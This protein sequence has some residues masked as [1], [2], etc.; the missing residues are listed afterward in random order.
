[1]SVRLTTSAPRRAGVCIIA[2]TSV[3]DATSK[4]DTAIF[5]VITGGPSVGKTTIISL[6]RE[7]GYPVV[8]EQATQ[9]IKEGKI[10][11]WVD[12]DL[13]QQ[14]VLRRQI[15]V[16][17]PYINSETPVFLDRG[18]FD[19]EAYY[20]CDGLPTPPVFQTMPQ[21]RYA[22]ALLIEELPF[23]DN[24]GVRFEDIEFTRKI[25]PVIEKCYT[26]RGIHVERVPALPPK[27]RVDYAVRVVSACLELHRAAMA[28]PQPA[29]LQFNALAL[30][31]G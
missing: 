27:E 18:L 29:M 5:V 1:M 11:P 28:P 4:G 25:T 12:R 22:M 30:A 3:A 9:I 17:S 24:N 10:L 14:E 8:D 2:Q 15:A 13:F 31:T 26:S 19:G 16:E 20:I 7:R 21:S 6:L 23:F